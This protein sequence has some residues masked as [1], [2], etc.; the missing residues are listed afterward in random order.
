MWTQYYNRIELYIHG[1]VQL[2]IDSPKV[3]FSLYKVIKAH[4]TAPR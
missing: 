4:A 2:P 1:T 3:M